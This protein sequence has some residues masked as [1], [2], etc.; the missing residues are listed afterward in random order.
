[1][2]DEPTLDELKIELMEKSSNSCC[3]CQIPFIHCHHIDKNRNNNTFDNLVPLCP[4]HHALAHSNSNMYL[5]LT[6]ERVKEIRDIW[7]EYVKKRKDN[8]IS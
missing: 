4:N 5:N 3:V 6:P 1:M 8:F 2:E 7:Y